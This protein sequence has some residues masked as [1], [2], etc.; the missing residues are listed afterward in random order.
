LRGFFENVIILTDRKERSDRQM[1][2]RL[3]EI[4]VYWN[5]RAE[6]YAQSN[7]EEL[8]GEARR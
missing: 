2:E 4:R 7:R 6:G 3:E 8:E 1:G 5:Q